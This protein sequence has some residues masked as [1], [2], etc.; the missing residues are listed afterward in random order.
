MLNLS[1][2]GLHLFLHFW[3]FVFETIFLVEK[4]AEFALVM[5]RFIVWKNCYL[6]LQSFDSSVFLLNFIKQFLA[7]CFSFIHKNSSFGKSGFILLRQGWDLI[8]VGFHIH[9]IVLFYSFSQFFCELSQLDSFVCEFFLQIFD[10]F[11]LLFTH[12]FCCG[13]LMLSFIYFFEPQQFSL[14]ILISHQYGLF[15]LF[16][17]FNFL[18]VFT[19][20]EQ[21]KNSLPAIAILF[22]NIGSFNRIHRTVTFLFEVQSFLVFFQIRF[23]SFRRGLRFICWSTAVHKRLTVHLLWLLQLEW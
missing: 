14:Q 9:V 12:L 15:F 2:W 19:C 8:F 18:Y 4:L 20:I 13:Y 10:Y 22:L 1:L 5:V 17:N 3:Y 7:L 23:I 11:C 21:L 16:L 6:L